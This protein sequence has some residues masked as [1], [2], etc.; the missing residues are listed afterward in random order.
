[1]IVYLLQW[2][3]NIL[4]IFYLILSFLTF[5]RSKLKKR[6]F[7]KLEHGHSN[8]GSEW[9]VRQGFSGV[10]PVWVELVMVVY[11]LH[12]PRSS[13]LRVGYSS[14]IFSY[15]CWTFTPSYSNNGRLQL[16]MVYKL[17]PFVVDYD[18]YPFFHLIFKSIHFTLM[19]NTPVNTIFYMYILKF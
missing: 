7:R 18:Q 14:F 10:P 11:M 16:I 17:V 19:V 2:S 15:T 3:L 6:D 5:L 13:N 12:V 8:F 4:F 1:M 9:D